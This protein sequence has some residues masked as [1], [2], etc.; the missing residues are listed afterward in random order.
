MACG[1]NKTAHMHQSWVCGDFAITIS[2]T[3][4]GVLAGIC[5]LGVQK[6]KFGLVHVHGYKAQ[7]PANKDQK[8]LNI[9]STGNAFL[10]ISPVNK[11]FTNG[12]IA[13]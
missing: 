11:I 1:G 10:A 8:I 7:T 12:E 9:V 3:C 5:N 4:P 6:C 13:R 2:Y